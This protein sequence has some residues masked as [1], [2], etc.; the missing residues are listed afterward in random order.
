MTRRQATRQTAAERRAAE[1]AI[2]ATPDCESGMAGWCSPLHRHERCYF[3]TTEGKAAVLAGTYGR[4]DSGHQWVCSCPCH[5]S[6][7]YPPCPTPTT[8]ASIN[9]RSLTSTGRCSSASSDQPRR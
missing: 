6:Q 8:Q 4:G 7:G 3:S 5:E 1:A 2:L 9:A